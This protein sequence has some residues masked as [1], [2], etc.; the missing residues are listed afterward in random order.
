LDL[1][2]WQRLN[3]VV[4]QFER[5]VLVSLEKDKGQQKLSMFWRVGGDGDGTQGLIHIRLWI[6]ILILSISLKTCV[7]SDP[8]INLLKL[9]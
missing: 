7:S 5:Q 6:I 4:K 8:G 1:A 3:D 9:L 2:D